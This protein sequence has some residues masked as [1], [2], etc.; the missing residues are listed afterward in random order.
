[1]RMKYKKLTVLLLLAA[2]A[3]TLR[4]QTSGNNSPYSRYGIGTLADEAQGFNKAMG[5]LS[6]SLNGKA[7]INRQNPASYAAI[8][9]L[10]LLFDIGASF[11]TAHMSY[12]GSSVNPQN[13][14][15]DYVQA[16]FRLFKNVGFSIGMRPYSIIGYNFTSTRTMDDIDGYGEKTNTATYL[17]EGG[18]HLAYAGMGWSPVKHFSVGANIGYIWGDYSHSTQVTFSETNIQS[19][20]RVYSGTIN[21]W[22]L[23]LGLQYAYDLNKNN[24]LSLGLTAGIGH[25]ID[26]QATFVNQKVSSS[27]VVGADTIHVGKAY[28]LPWSFGGGLSWK[29]KD[30]WLIGI[31]YTC[32]LWKNSRF[33][34][35]INE[36]GRQVYRVTTSAMSNRQKIVVGGQYIPNSDGFRF[37]DH[38]NYRF[39][40]S[41]ATSYYKM[42]GE[43]GPKNYSATFG[44][45]LPIMNQYSNRS[46]LNL[47]A[48]Y[49]HAATSKS[50]WIKENYF[51]LCVGLTF[52]ARWF[53]KWKFE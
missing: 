27:A 31:D 19:L 37:R 42:N 20:R 44:V 47:T 16:A 29:Y 10:T 53:N 39:G 50:G 36:N 40:L 1:M 51:R 43:E 26:Q 8:D 41:Y 7:V 48:Q 9:S 23:D 15:L 32:Q 34:Q 12:N 5:G 4:A 30:R 46:M 24:R 3:S 17:G 2:S 14:T 22:Q 45:G 38:V 25:K 35:L 6:Q 21:T 13:T 49:E 33:P 11:S 28:E 18:L 52:N